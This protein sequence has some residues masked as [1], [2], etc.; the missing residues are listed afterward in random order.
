M[1]KNLANMKLWR[2]TW[3]HRLPTGRWWSSGSCF[4]CFTKR[5]ISSGT[6]NG[7]KWSDAR[8]ANPVQMIGTGME[9]HVT[10]LG[11]TAGIPTPFRT[12]S[13]YVVQCRGRKWLVDAGEGT[14]LKLSQLESLSVADLEGIFITHLH[15]DHVFGLHSLVATY[16]TISKTPFSEQWMN[17]LQGTGPHSKRA[18]TKQNQLLWIYGPKGL[19]NYIFN[20]FP[21]L[22]SKQKARFP[23]V[24]VE[25]LKP[26]ESPPEVRNSYS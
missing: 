11:T 16:L 19:A 8:R 7:I 18:T 6:T 2:S 3:H 20:G 25:L 17:I 14:F 9:A 22:S 26:D 1:L 21:Y 23:I 12:T 4:R 15:G 24:V 5:W 13:G 10:V